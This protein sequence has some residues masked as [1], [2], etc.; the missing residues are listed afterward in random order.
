MIR[1]PRAPSSDQDRSHACPSSQKIGVESERAA[2]PIL[3]AQGEASPSPGPPCSHATTSQAHQV[4]PT[5]SLNGSEPTI[6]AGEQDRIPWPQSL[7]NCRSF[8]GQ[9]GTIT[10]QSQF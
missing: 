2:L 3:T 8:S 9:T 5:R 1:L 4:K 10:E 6:Q 7:D